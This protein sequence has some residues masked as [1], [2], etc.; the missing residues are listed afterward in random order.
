MNE[1]ALSPYRWIIELLL[2][3]LLTAQ[4]I[5][6]LAPAPILD[7]IK[8]GSASRSARADLSFQSSHCASVSSRSSVR[9]FLKNWAPCDACSLDSG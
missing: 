2:L 5:T 9:S 4:S 8:K 1:R 6:W 3:L 7:E